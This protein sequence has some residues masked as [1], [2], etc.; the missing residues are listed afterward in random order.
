MTPRV[1]LVTLIVLVVRTIAL[2]ATATQAHAVQSWDQTLGCNTVATCPRF[3]VL[4]NFN[5]QAVLDRE[6]GLV[7]QQSPSPQGTYTWANAVIACI[8]PLPS[9]GGRGGWRLPTIYELMTLVDPTTFTLPAG[10]P[11]KLDAFTSPSRPQNVW[12]TSLVP[13]NPNA[14]FALQTGG[15]LFQPSLSSTLNVWC[16]RG[17]QGANTP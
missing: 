8:D 17:G 5:N 6:T 4:S 13:G 11:F 9:A 10:H 14:A 16:V 7:W 1:L 3:T 2:S 15:G 12:S